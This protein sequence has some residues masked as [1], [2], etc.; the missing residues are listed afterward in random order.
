MWS[1][2]DG[3]GTVGHE[4][5]AY[6][7]RSRRPDRTLAPLPTPSAIRSHLAPVPT[8]LLIA[9]VAAAS[10]AAFRVSAGGYVRDWKE[11]Q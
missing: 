1:S 11:K 9:E 3:A 6:A 7:V 10:V 8:V 4:N 2:L 5:E